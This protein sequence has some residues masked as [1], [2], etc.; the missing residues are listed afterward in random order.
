M[1]LGHWPTFQKLHI[2]SLS[3]PEGS[4]SSCFLLYGQ[5]L[6]RYRPIFNSKFPYLG[7][8]FIILKSLGKGERSMIS[9][10]QR[11]HTCNGRSCGSIIKSHT[12]GRESKDLGICSSTSNDSIHTGNSSMAAEKTIKHSLYDLLIDIEV[13][14]YFIEN[15]R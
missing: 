8:K 12:A 15:T 1:K 14:F 6:L 2:Y 11:G 3:T 5:R 7:M 13:P 10:E 4:K 9:R